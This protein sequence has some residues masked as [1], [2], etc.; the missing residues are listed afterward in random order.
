MDLLPYAVPVALFALAFGYLGL[1][2][3]WTNR[4]LAAKAMNSMDDW[5]LGPNRGAPIKWSATDLIQL[6]LQIV[7]KELRAG[8]RLEGLAR[9]FFSPQRDWSLSPRRLRCPL[10]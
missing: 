10:I 4:D 8:E 3:A 5:T 2:V 1:R 6:G 7:D 9:G